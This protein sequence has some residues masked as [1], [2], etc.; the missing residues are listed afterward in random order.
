MSGYS[1]SARQKI[2]MRIE[3]L[4]KQ[5]ALSEDQLLHL[6]FI[7]SRDD[8]VKILADRTRRLFRIDK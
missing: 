6:Q 5:K 4:T 1:S 7:F 3:K 8:S 2:A